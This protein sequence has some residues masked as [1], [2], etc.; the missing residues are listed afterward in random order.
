MGQSRVTVSFIPTCE[1]VCISPNYPIVFGV[2][3]GVGL[4][5]S[6]A[7][8]KGLKLVRIF[9]LARFYFY[10]FLYPY[11]THFCIRFVYPFFATVFFHSKLSEQ[12]LIYLGRSEKPIIL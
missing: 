1:R 8:F 3:A 4:L 10:R 11:C 2:G 7:V 9:F 6:L 5:L 12:F